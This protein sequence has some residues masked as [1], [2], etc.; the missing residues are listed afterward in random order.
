M[1]ES[2]S[3]KTDA[4]L[5]LIGNFL[6]NII[7]KE[8]FR[9]CIIGAG[10]AGLAAIKVLKDK[11]VQIDCYERSDK[12]GGHWQNDYEALHLI[13]PKS[14]SAFL[15]YP[16]P[17]ACAIYPSREEICTYMASYAAAFNLY[18][19]ITFNAEVEKITP[20][21]DQAE[22]GWD[23]VV[24]GKTLH[25]DGVIVANGHLWHPVF[26]PE[27][28]DYTGVSLHS[29]QYKNT[30]Q[31]EGKV[32]VVGCGNSGCD[33][34]VDAAQ[35]RLNSTIVMRHGQVFQPKTL[36]GL[37]RAELPFIDQL[38]NEL[39]K[40]MSLFLISVSLGSW[41]NYPGMP[42]PVT[43]DLEKQPPIVNNL[44]LYWIQHGRVKVV[45]GIHHIEGKKVTFD[46]G[47]SEEFGTIVWATGFETY[48]P[49]LDEHLLEWKE[50]IPLRTGGTILPSTELDNIYFVGLTSPRG[51]QWP[52]Y[53]AQTELIYR[54]LKLKEKGYKGLTKTFRK[55]QEP[56]DEI[57][58]VRKIWFEGLN[59]SHRLMDLL[60]ET[61]LITKEVA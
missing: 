34:A 6:R 28:A 7:M 53:N 18:D 4:F 20:V 5:S 40:A 48:M 30:S 31:I 60:E 2:K 56:D 51:A 8:N 16:M 21:G 38:P 27:A 61:Y 46:D 9:Y 42:E 17:E 57:L 33:I 24:Q 55:Q 25:Y 45:P 47:T 54:Y 1:E 15:D 59:Q 13:T 58:K 49:F 50:G 19:H 32:L 52:A 26:P 35:H 22:D 10:A 3:I 12:V 36:F 23:V 29:S 41:K 43:W 39:Q 37:P 14:T 11:K 44:L